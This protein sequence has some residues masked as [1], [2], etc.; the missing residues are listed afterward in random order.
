[1]ADLILVKLYPLQAFVG[2]HSRG[3]VTLDYVT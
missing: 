3:L 1:M 2:L